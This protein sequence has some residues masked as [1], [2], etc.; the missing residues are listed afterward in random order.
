MLDCR[1]QRSGAIHVTDQ[2]LC[3]KLVSKHVFVK[4]CEEYEVI[5]PKPETLN[6]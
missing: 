1:D 4:P 6:V 5:S 3:P 2:G